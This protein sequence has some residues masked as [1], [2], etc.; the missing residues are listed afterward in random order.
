MKKTVTVR[1]CDNDGAPAKPVR[2]KVNNGPMREKDL[3]EDCIGEL[4]DKSR[5]AQR[6]KP[7]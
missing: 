5:P 2:F 4:M 1:V 3:C 7:A 6:G